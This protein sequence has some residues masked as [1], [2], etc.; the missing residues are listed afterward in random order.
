M[1]WLF[2]LL[3]ILLCRNLHYFLQFCLTIFVMENFK[4]TTVERKVWRI[5][6]Y[7]SP[8]SEIINTFAHLFYLSPPLFLNNILK[9]IPSIISFYL[10]IQFKNR[11][12]KNNLCFIIT[13]NSLI[14]LKSGPY[15]NFWL[16]QKCLSQLVFQIRFRTQ[17]TFYASLFSFHS[18]S[19]PFPFSLP[20]IF[21]ID[22]LEEQSF[23]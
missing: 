10:W 11:C 22:F 17:T 18:I 5:L 16:P 12:F 13:S 23:I 9:H 3:I 8:T 6:I 21:T 2:L 1:L 14:F 19:L 4:Q 20:F 7:L 15:S